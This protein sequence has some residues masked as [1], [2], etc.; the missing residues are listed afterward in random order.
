MWQGDF[1]FIRFSSIFFFS[2]KVS[3][4]TSLNKWIRKN[5]LQKLQMLN[6]LSEVYRHDSTFNDLILT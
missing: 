6:K 2:I 4:P 1:F 5:R 3:T